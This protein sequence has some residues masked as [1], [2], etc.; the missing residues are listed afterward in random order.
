MVANEKS[1]NGWGPR[2]GVMRPGI[3]PNKFMNLARID[4]STGE[5]KILHS[6]PQASQGS[7]LVTNG[8]LVFWG[9]ANRRV[10]A[11]DADSGKVL[12]ESIVGGIVMTGTITYAVNGKQYVAILTGSG[13]SVTAGPLGLTKKSMPPAVRGHN[14]IVVFALPEK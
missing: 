5:M 11:F 3:D 7:A 14:S 2:R 4:L 12:W 8:D 6:Q 1:K 10:R 13:Q 9:D